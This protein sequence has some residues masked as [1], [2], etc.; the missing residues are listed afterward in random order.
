VNRRLWTAVGL[1]IMVMGGVSFIWGP[2]RIGAGG[3]WMVGAAREGWDLIARLPWEV[4][5]ALAALAAV[6]GLAAIRWDRRRQRGEAEPWRTVIQMGREGRSPSVIARRTGLS[7]DAVRIVL[8]PIAVDPSF[9][10]GKSFRSTGA[11]PPS[12]ARSDRSAP[13]S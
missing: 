3:G 2:G 6:L 13:P 5:V 9:P 7:Q 11:A 8:A 10:R 12:R 4:V 1:T